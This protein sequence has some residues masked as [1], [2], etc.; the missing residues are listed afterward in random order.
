MAATHSE[1]PE[2][3]AKQVRNVLLK[4]V[5]I[6]VGVLVFSALAGVWLDHNLH[7]EITGPAL[8]PSAPVSAISNYGAI[9]PTFHLKTAAPGIWQYRPLAKISTKS[10][11]LDL[12]LVPGK[13]KETLLTIHRYFTHQTA[14]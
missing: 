12:G 6:P 1:S 2:A 8:R 3:F 11:Q 9:T 5:A 14:A 7:S 10:V 13:P 4:G